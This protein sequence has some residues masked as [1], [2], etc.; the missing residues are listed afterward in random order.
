MTL[1]PSTCTLFA[2]G[3]TPIEVL[4]HCKVSL[5]LK[6]SFF[7]ETDF[8]VSPSINE[9]MLSIDWLTKNAARW[10]FQEG[11]IMIRDPTSNIDETYSSH[12][13]IG[14]EFAVRSIHT[15]KSDCT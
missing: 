5:Q 1:L 2:A 6:N 14:R 9:P 4:G 12:A 10:N 7:I 3:G 13:V 11:T 15:S 8:I